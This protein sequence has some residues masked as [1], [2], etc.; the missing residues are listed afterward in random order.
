MNKRPFTQHPT[1]FIITPL[2]VILLFLFVLLPQASPTVAANT[3]ATNGACVRF[4]LYQGRNAATGAGVAGR[5]DMREVTTGSLLASWEASSTATVSDWFTNLQQ[6]SDGGSWVEVFFYEGG[7]E[8]AVPLEILNP[9]PNTPYGWVTNGQCHAVELQFPTDWSITES[10]SSTENEEIG[11]G[12]G[13]D[14]WEANLSTITPIR[15]ATFS[16]TPSFFEV[17][18]FG[19]L[20][21]S[22]ANA[23]AYGF[24]LTNLA[25]DHFIT[26][27]QIAV[28]A[29]DNLGIP[30]AV[31]F[32]NIRDIFPSETANIGNVLCHSDI[33]AEREFEAVEAADIDRIELVFVSASQL[34]LSDEPE[35]LIILPLDDI[36]VFYYYSM[37]PISVAQS[38]IIEEGE[39]QVIDNNFL[40]IN[41]K[42]FNPN[43]SFAASNI[44]ISITAFDENEAILSQFQT[45]FAEEILP[46]Q[47]FRLNLDLP[48]ERPEELH[49]VEA[50]FDVEQFMPVDPKTIETSVIESVTVSYDEQTALIE[51]SPTNGL[52]LPRIYH[53]TLPSGTSYDVVG[54]ATARDKN[55]ETIGGGLAQPFFEDEALKFLIPIQASEAPETIGIYLNGEFFVVRCRCGGGG[56]IIGR[57]DFPLEIT[58]VRLDR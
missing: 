53:G 29:Y 19:V 38:E 41:L 54:I 40:E 14:S 24:T 50:V 15:N 44:S 48:L 52:P 37:P 39:F 55:G 9:A 3:P 58:G 26:G 42:L 21:D 45:T 18:N 13:G 33:N 22:E 43:S 2:L 32:E 28:V 56:N 1:L 4:S 16:N 20:I 6:V 31:C 49:H 7:V 25:D 12:G 51:I 47:S 34:A 27:L 30:L 36:D 5:Y 11:I 46:R 17:S 8:T 57:D 35:S 10:D 23:A